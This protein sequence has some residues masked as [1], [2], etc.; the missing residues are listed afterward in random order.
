M[1]HRAHGRD[2]LRRNDTKQNER[3]ARPP[4]FLTPSA[5][6]DDTRVTGWGLG[7][8]SRSLARTRLQAPGRE[9]GVCHKPHCLRESVGTASQGMAGALLTSPW[10][11]AK[12]QQWEQAPQ[13][14]A[15]RACGGSPLPRASPVSCVPA[16]WRQ[17]LSQS[18]CDKLTVYGDVWP[19][20]AGGSP[21]WSVSS[22]RV[23]HA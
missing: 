12:A 8:G 7:M 4:G 14:T 17:R 10:T 21:R 23:G 5:L 9:A 6:M 3:R 1:C 13:R 18:G 22:R 11:P 16:P 15:A 19:T 20:G 2:V